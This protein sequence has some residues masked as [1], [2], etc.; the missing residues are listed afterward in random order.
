MN[1][2]TAEQRRGAL[3]STW[4]ALRD[5]GPR[6]FEGRLSELWHPDVA[7]YGPQ[8][9]NH[10]AGLNAFLS[11]FWRPFAAAF[12]DLERVCDI[13]VADDFNGRPWVAATGHYVGTFKRP[14]LGIAASNSVTTIRY[15][16]FSRF[17]NGRVVEIYTIVDVLDVM[18]QAGQWPAVLPVSLGSAERIPGPAAQDG[19]LAVSDPIGAGLQSRK[20]VEAM[21][22]GLMQYDGK[23]LAS[24][25]MERFWHPNMMW[26]GPA[27]IG[28]ARGLEGFQRCHQVPFLIAFPDRIGGDHR[29]RLAEGPYV[30]ST[31]W[32]S[33]RA[34]HLGDGWLGVP[35]TGKRISMRVMDFWRREQALLLENW[36]FIDMIDLLG[37]MG[38]SVLKTGPAA[39]R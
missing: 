25:A 39:A 5:L 32:P 31:G 34:T 12:P 6:A 21:I 3:A 4:A 17:E 37:Q 10:L 8:P 27:G 33:V 1:A 38:V 9:F 11:T 16:E 7:W 35:A 15:G 29:A 2:E 30:A 28:S 14:W 23:T 18:R 26:Y 19:L 22:V 13:A 20:L 36:V 24:M